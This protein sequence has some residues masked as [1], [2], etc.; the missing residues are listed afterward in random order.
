MKGGCGLGNVETALVAE[1]GHCSCLLKLLAGKAVEQ[2]CLGCGQPARGL[3][4]SVCCLRVLFG[5]FDNHEV[6]VKR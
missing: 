3:I 5:L 1:Q 6:E 4:V 2:M